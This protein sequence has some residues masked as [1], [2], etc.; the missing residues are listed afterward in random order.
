M[1]PKNGSHIAAQAFRILRSL[2]QLSVDLF[3]SEN[4]DDLNFRILNNTIYLFT[5]NRAVLW[6]FEKKRPRLLGISGQAEVKSQSALSRLWHDIIL[7]VKDKQSLQVLVPEGLVQDKE[8]QELIEKTSGLSVLYAPVMEGGQL[9]AVLW[10]ERWGESRWE[11][12]ECEIMQ[13]LARSIGLAWRQFNPRPRRISRIQG[14]LGGLLIAVAICLLVI[15]SIPLRV[16]APCEIMP[17]EPH[18]VTAPLEGVIK[19]VLV[20]PGDYVGTGDLLFT[21]EDRILMH[22][23]KVAQKQVQI[24]QSQYDRARLKAFKDQEALGKIKSLGY[25][26]EQERI[27]LRL[28]ETNI[29]HLLVRAPTDGICVVDNPENWSGRPV[30]IGER[31]VMIFQPEKSKIRIFLPENDNIRF[32]RRRLVKVILNADPASS[33]KARLDYVAP[34]TSNDPQGRAAFMAEAYFVSEDARVKVG[35]KGSAIVY[36]EKVSIGFWLIRKPMAGIR[37]Y[38]GL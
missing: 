13:S 1:P 24:I 3:A 21:Y 25:R 17:R 19:E 9:R 18:M 31:V 22:E 33:Y 27:R 36:G 7:S 10:L 15:L 4:R 26:L 35:S 34:Q 38:T 14:I 23:L 11:A 37:R 5:Y 20:K 30:M 8:W 16:V 12:S 29:E 32:D 6:S 2:H 28:T